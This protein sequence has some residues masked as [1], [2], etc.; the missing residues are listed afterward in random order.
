[1]ENKAARNV[2][3]RNAIVKTA[4][5][6]M[7]EPSSLVASVRALLAFAMSM[8]IFESSCVRKA[9]NCALKCWCFLEFLGWTGFGDVPLRTGSGPV[10]R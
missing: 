2:A 5:V 10:F 1:M 9:N 3:G 7:E 6:F 8:L 4:I